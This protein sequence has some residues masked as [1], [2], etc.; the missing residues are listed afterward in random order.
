[1]Q[2][3]VDDSKECFCHFPI[4]L[5]CFMHCSGQGGVGKST[6]LKQL[7]LLWA[8]RQSD[9]LK[10]FD[11]MFH[12]ALNSVKRGESLEYL[13]LEQHKGLGRQNVDAAD[14]TKILKGEEQCKVLLMLDGYDEYTPGT[15]TNIDK[16]IKKFSLPNCC[17]ILTSRDTKELNVLRSYMDTEAE[18]TGF[19]HERVEQYITK[20]LESPNE[21][22]N[23][24]QI[25]RETNLMTMEDYGILQVPIMLHMIC[26]LYQQKVSLPKT[27]TGVI[28]AIVERCPD[29]EEIRRSGQKTDAEVKGLLETAL[30][31]LG[32]LCWL[33][34]QAGSKDLIFLKVKLLCKILTL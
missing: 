18:I 3:I 4:F 12:V 20:Y 2:G 21:C 28:S 16:A 33:R 30:I 31:N 8:S 1:M 23:L 14:I 17:L 13:I 27:I 10:E 29:W 11:F 19:D 34:L 32:K 25:A 24:L 9:E 22:K 5:H 15:N 6:S 7:A 26:V